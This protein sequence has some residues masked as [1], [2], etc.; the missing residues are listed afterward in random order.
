MVIRLDL[1]IVVDGE[2]VPINKFVMEI[3]N[4]MIV[5]ALSSLKGIRENW[6]EIEIKI[7]R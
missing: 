2:E 1:K 6:K 3:L 5:G 4:G 7:T